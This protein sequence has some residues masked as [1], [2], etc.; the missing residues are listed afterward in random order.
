M[1]TLDA[2]EFALVIFIPEPSF[3]LD[4]A[5][6]EEFEMWAAILHRDE[7]GVLAEIKRAPFTDQSEALTAWKASAED[8][9][10]WKALRELA[11]ALFPDVESQED[12]MREDP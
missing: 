4:D 11:L 9:S 5:P 7:H 10:K 6:A 2:G 1:T 8:E 3:T 12:D